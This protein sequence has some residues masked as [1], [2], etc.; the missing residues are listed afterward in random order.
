MS[1]NDPGLLFSVSLSVCWTNALSNSSFFTYRSPYFLFPLE[2]PLRL[3]RDAGTGLLSPISY[4]LGG[5][6]LTGTPLT[7]ASNA[8]GYEK[9]TIFDQ[10]LVVS[11]KWIVR[12][13]HSARQFVSIGFSLHPY[14]KLLCIH[15]TSAWL[16]QGRPQ[17]KQ[18]CG[19]NSDFWT[20]A[21]T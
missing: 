15:T 4:A 17:G 10:Y 13:A 11:Q 7:G 20:Y 14:N 18:K 21:L 19:Q 12:W 6:I 3:S 2:T 16:P 1:A 5:A 8:R 9:M